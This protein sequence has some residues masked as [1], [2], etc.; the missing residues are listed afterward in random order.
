MKKKFSVIIIVALLATL[1]IFTSCAVSQTMGSITATN[2]SDSLDALNVSVG[3]VYIGYVGKGQTVT[4]YF[5][6]PQSSAL[7]SA[8]NFASGPGMNGKIDLKLDYQYYLTFGKSQTD[9]KNEFLI[10]GVKLG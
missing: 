8:V 10:Y 4:V 7:I 2:N 3:S 9:N 6:I 1:F 5:I